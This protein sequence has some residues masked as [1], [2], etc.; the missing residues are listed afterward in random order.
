MDKVKFLIIRFSSIGDIVLTTPVVRMLKKQVEN[1]EVHYLT[2][3]KFRYLVDANPHIDKVHAYDGNMVALLES[4]KDEGFDYVIDLHRNLRSM[5][6][7][8]ALRR[9]AFSFRKL[10]FRKWIYVRYKINRMPNL[11]IVD[12]YLE[13]VSLFDVQND[14]Q[15][16]DYFF[17]KGFTPDF[18]IPDSHKKGYIVAV[19]GANHVTKQIP[20]IQLVEILNNAEKPVVLLGGENEKIIASELKKDLTIPVFDQCGKVSVDGSAHL[21]E[22]AKIVLTPDTGMMHIA[23]A[24]EKQIVS[25]WGNTT[26]ELGMYPYMPQKPENFFIAEVKGLSCRPCSKIGFKKC[27]KRHFDC[28]MK[29]DIPAIVSQINFYWNRNE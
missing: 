15:G 8:N 3:A 27:P 14:N 20:N 10:N 23:A 4:L 25:I 6:V 5:R 28:M 9:M 29:Q 2:K 7:K 1:A 17:S 11:H 19:L 12:R 22:N 18:Q 16:L 26:P 24:L 13:T 21:I